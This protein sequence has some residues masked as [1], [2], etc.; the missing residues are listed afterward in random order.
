MINPLAMLGLIVFGV[1]AYDGIYELGLGIVLLILS[2]DWDR[3]RM[4]WLCNLGAVAM[5]I[6][7]LLI[8][9]IFTSYCV[10]L[11]PYILNLS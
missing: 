5:I 8:M 7:G 10:S 6:H 9:I 4:R 2:G 3:F 1:D 11:I